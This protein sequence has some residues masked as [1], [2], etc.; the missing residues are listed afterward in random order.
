MGDFAGLRNLGWNG[1]IHEV[2]SGLAFFWIRG[3]LIQ[4]EF[5][6]SMKFVLRFSLARL[7]LINCEWKQLGKLDIITKNHAQAGAEERM[8]TTRL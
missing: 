6:L 4:R 7:S 2:L 1:G 8:A 5:F 3:F